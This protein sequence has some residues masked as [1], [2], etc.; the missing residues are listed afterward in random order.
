MI[1]CNSEQGEESWVPQQLDSSP[2]LKL[3]Q[4]YGWIAYF[5]Q[6]IKS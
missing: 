3:A 1:T 5:C 6:S 4:N 2:H